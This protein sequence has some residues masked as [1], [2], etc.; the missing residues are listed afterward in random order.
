MRKSINMYI[1]FSFGL[2]LTATHVR[3]NEAEDK[4]VAAIKKLGDTI[5]GDAKAARKPGKEEAEKRTILRPILLLVDSKTQAR[6]QAGNSGINSFKRP[7]VPKRVE[8]PKKSAAKTTLR[9][10]KQKKDRNSERFPASPKTLAA[11]NKDFAVKS[12]SMT[13]ADNTVIECRALVRMEDEQEVVLDKDI[14]M[15]L[16]IETDS[17]QGPETWYCYVSVYEGSVAPSADPATQTNDMEGLQGTWRIASSQHTDETFL[18]EEDPRGLKV[19]A[20]GD[21]LTYYSRDERGRYEGRFHLD[22]V[23]QAFD[24]TPAYSGIGP[25]PGATVSFR[26]IYELKGDDL[27]FYFHASKWERPKTFDFKEGW[28]LVL[29]RDAEGKRGKASAVRDQAVETIR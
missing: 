29:N 22:P 26:G 1:V 24:W 8:I 18:F 15:A 4:A 3:A 27:K 12:V 5:T 16:T 23:T 25:S 10:A 13:L 11:Y 6:I 2:V 21:T 7:D 17:D 14:I 28:L 9:R 19:V 20:K